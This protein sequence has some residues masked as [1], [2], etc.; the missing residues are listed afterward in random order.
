MDFNL[1]YQAQIKRVTNAKVPLTAKPRKSKSKQ[2]FSAAS[3][4]IKVPYHLA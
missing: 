4:K 3:L 2:K 1:F